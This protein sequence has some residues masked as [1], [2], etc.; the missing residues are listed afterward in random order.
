MNCL[1]SATWR[2]ACSD[3]QAW[4]ESFLGVGSP[5]TTACRFGG[6]SG[7]RL[8]GDLGVPEFTNMGRRRVGPEF[9]R[10]W[11][12]ADDGVSVRSG[13]RGAGCSVILGFRSSR[14][15][16]GSDWDRSFAQEAHT[17]RRRVGAEGTWGAWERGRRSVGPEFPRSWLTLDDGDR[18]W[19]WVRRGVGADGGGRPRNP[20]TSR[21]L[22]GR[23]GSRIGTCST[24]ESRPFWT[25]SSE[26]ELPGMFK[27]GN[28]GIPD[29]K[30]WDWVPWGGTPGGIAAEVVRG[31]DVPTA[32]SKLVRKPCRFLT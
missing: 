30:T 16:D 24:V 2:T 11:F 8:L 12:T 17:G 22:S 14:T 32:V 1:S 28:L 5:R 27:S 21:L 31:G 26:Q 20:W 3:G 6:G 4:A 10:S 15:W 23:R 13:L 29:G 19:W 18:R 25:K 9:P 7:G